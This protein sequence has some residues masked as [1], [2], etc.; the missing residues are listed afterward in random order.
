MDRI[1]AIEHVMNLRTKVNADLLFI[2]AGTKFRGESLP[3]TQGRT[4]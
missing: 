3:E 4:L 2:A 1:A